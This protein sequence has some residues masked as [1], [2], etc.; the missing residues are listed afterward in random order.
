MFLR[1]DAAKTVIHKS[2]LNNLFIANVNISVTIFFFN[3]IFR[4][5]HITIQQSLFVKYEILFFNTYAKHAIFPN[6]FIKV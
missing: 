4:K 6:K 1:K 3:F 5:K 2:A